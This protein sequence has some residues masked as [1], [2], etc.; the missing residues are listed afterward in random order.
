VNADRMQ[1]AIALAVRAH[2][3]QVR[4]S[5]EIPYVVHPIGVGMILTQS[6][7]DEELVIAGL[8]HDVIE[9]SDVRVSEIEREFGTAVARIVTACTEDKSESWEVRKQRFVAGMREAPKN[10]QIVVC[11]DK[12]DNVLSMIRDRARCGAALWD[13]FNRGFEMQR[14]HYRALVKALVGLEGEAIYSEFCRS[15]DRLFSGAAD[16]K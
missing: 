13:R 8:L 11:A 15:V 2:S 12:L 4:K 6:G 3:G 14:A 9:E 10:V 7:Y 5:T 16:G 1:R